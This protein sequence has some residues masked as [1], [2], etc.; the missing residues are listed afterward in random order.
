[1][2]HLR[3]F[4]DKLVGTAVAAFFLAVHGFDDFL[5]LF[6]SEEGA[7]VGNRPEPGKTPGAVGI[8]GEDDHIVK[9]IDDP[10]RRMG[11]DDDDLSLVRNL[12]QLAPVGVAFGAWAE[13]ETVGGYTWTYRINGD[14]AEISSVSATLEPGRKS[15][16]FRMPAVTLSCH[17]RLPNRMTI[18]GF[19]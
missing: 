10:V 17:V 11:N 7:R 9:Q 8:F 2:L 14:T 4:H 19:R 6:F 12:A 1:M 5:H 15:E 16:L 3:I 18:K 13:E